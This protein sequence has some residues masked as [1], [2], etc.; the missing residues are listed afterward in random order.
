MAQELLNLAD[1][2][3]SAVPLDL[4]AETYFDFAGHPFTH[5][6]L[7]DQTSSVCG[8]ILAIDRYAARWLEDKIALKRSTARVL[9]NKTPNAA[10][11][12]GSFEVILEEGTVFDPA[13][14]VGS[15][16]SGTTHSIFLERGAQV[17]GSDIYLS[18]GS[19][20]LG[21]GT[22]VEPGAGIK[23]PTIVG[24]NTEIR[25]GAYLRGDCILGSGCT[26]R[27]EIKNT[28]IM[29]RANFP[30]PSYV[31]DS[32]CGYMT[33]FGNQATAANL[34]IY[35]GLR[36]AGERSSIKLTCGG[37]TY[38]IGNSKMGVCMGDFSQVGCSS[39]ADPGTFFKPYTVSY[40]LTRIK[41]GFYGPRE[42]LKNKPLEHGI[43]ERAPL[44]WPEA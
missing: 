11:T 27:G 22:T 1:L 14:V 10:Y 43:I 17:I 7:F 24:K 6:A 31:G 33:H 38:D 13:R 12:L 26:I 40:S 25:Q 28:V 21:A 8:A 35:E 41:K 37:K 9:T 30:H 18:G 39:V 16:P 42:V 4:R 34:G 23:G 20:Y 44:A 32:T 5:R 2:D 3:R 36:E 19:V 29:D 15:G